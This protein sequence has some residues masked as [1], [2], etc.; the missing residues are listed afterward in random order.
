MTHLVGKAARVAV[1]SLMAALLMG[2]SAMAAE[3]G[4]AVAIGATTGSALRLRSEPSTSASIITMLDEDVPVAVL[5]NTLD[6]WYKINY[7]GNTG[8]VSADYML[9]D[10]DNVFD[11]FG[12]VEG[13]GVNVRSIPSTDGQVLTVMNRNSI[14]TV[15]GF[16]DGWYKIKANGV[17]G[18]LR[19]DYLTMCG[20]STN[21]NPNTSS[22][23]SSSSSNAVSSLGEAAGDVV[24]FAKQYLGTRYVYGGS[25][26]S[27][28]DCS[29]FTMYVFS[30]HGY[31]LPHSATSQWN[32]S[33]TYV[34]KSDL[35]PGDLVLFCDPSRSNG[36][37]CSHVGIYIGNNEF[38]HAS[39]GSSGKYVRTNSLSESYYSGYYV[40]A[41][42]VG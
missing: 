20:S 26:P 13:E 35:Q 32:N 1:L 10:R 19:S 31:N 7:N 25:T 36:K 2:A 14:A 6:G 38:V 4:I 9:I 42:R 16:A 34:E 37:A 28:F 15:S 23:G 11:A 21:F 24:S 17:E 40:G 30:L 27:G 5:D 39:S 29:G 12:R 8:F 3:D 33:G 18:Y 22:S 41:K